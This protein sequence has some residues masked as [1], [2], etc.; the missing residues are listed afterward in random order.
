[1][2]NKYQKAQDE[3]EVNTQAE[4][5]P[6]MP[7]FTL[8]SRFRFFKAYLT[9]FHY[10]FDSTT[11]LL[12]TGHSLIHPSPFS[13]VDANAGTSPARLVVSSV[14]MQ[15]RRR[16]LYSAQS[17]VNRTAT[18]VCVHVYERD[19]MKAGA[20]LH[21]R[22]SRLWDS[23]HFLFLQRMLLAAVCVCVCVCVCLCGGGV[24]CILWPRQLTF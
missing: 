18:C 4:S 21:P 17:D 20:L 19:V 2:R 23:C 14:S 10:T 12:R 22:L 15:L 7:H 16:P 3:H 24:L 9:V 6:S 8:Y 13:W 5:F 11:S 1:M